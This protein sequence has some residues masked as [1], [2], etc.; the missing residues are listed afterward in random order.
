[1]RRTK[2]N[3]VKTRI[4]LASLLTLFS[5]SLASATPIT[6]PSGLAPGATYYLVFVTAGARDA[7]ST[8]IADYDGFVTAQASLDPSLLALGTTWKAIGS[9]ATVDAATHLGLIGS[10]IYNLSGQLVATNSS[11]LFDTN[12][13][14]SIQ[15]D[16]FG[17]LQQIPVWTGSLSNGQG[18][19]GNLLGEIAPEF[20]LS[21]ESSASWITF[22]QDFKN[23]SFALYGISGP[24]VAP[25]AAVPE[26]GTISLML[27]PALLLLGR[28]RT[29]RSRPAT[30]VTPD[31]HSPDDQG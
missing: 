6:V 4:L 10:P 7:T 16:Q 20:G 22:G 31:L 15:Y 21:Y 1:M 29:R 13:T 30:P 11:D 27:G 26:P 8:N 23:K 18:V 9:T 19:S 28:Y 25:G 12:I 14:N 5:A 2:E 17:N 24:F 3:P